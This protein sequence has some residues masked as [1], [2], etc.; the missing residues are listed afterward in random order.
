MG[1]GKVS[2]GLAP[3]SGSGVVTAQFV[4]SQLRSSMSLSTFLV[5]LGKRHWCIEDEQ[6]RRLGQIHRRAQ[7]LF[8]LEPEGEPT[9]DAIKGEY[10]SQRAVMDTIIGCTGGPCRMKRKS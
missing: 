10:P 9:L 5:P 2:Q 4:I 6:G 1:V 8:V 3:F 7:Q